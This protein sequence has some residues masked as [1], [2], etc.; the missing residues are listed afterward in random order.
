MNISDSS[1]KKMFNCLKAME[2]IQ[3]IDGWTNAGPLFDA[4]NN[5]DD[6]LSKELYD[7]NIVMSDIQAVFQRENG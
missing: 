5:L 6:V 7:N 1:K 2:L 4:F 3:E